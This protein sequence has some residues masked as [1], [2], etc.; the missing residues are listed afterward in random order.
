[1]S[2]NR[3][4]TDSS[5]EGC[6]KG[7]VLLSR[8]SLVRSQCDE[9]GLQRVYARLPKAERIVLKGTIDPTAWYPFEVCDRL[10]LAIASELGGGLE[11]IFLGFGA[12][13]AEDNLPKTHASFLHS[14]DPH[15]LL[16]QAAEIYQLYY[17]TGYRTY[18]WV[19]ANQAVLRTFEARAFSRHDCFTVIG[20]HEKAIEMCGGREPKVTEPLCRARGDARCEYVCSWQ[21]DSVSPRTP[22]R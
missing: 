8:L 20:W 18:E 11:R 2:T 14:K 13:S 9:G 17:N 6:V 12:R 16:K 5:L 22:L 21:S 7:A 15:G 4:H 10:D 19:A 3:S 1:M